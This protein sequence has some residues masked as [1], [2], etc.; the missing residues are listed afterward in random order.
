LATI[1]LH[2]SRRYFLGRLVLVPLIG[3]S[4][5]GVVEIVLDFVIPYPHGR[6]LANLT[7]EIFILPA[8][9]GLLS[10]ILVNRRNVPPAHLFAWL[11]PCAF[12]VWQWFSYPDSGYSWQYLLSDHC[13]DNECLSELFV[14]TPAVF[15][16][17][18][19]AGTALQ[20]LRLWL[21]RLQAD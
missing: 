6:F 7:V 9:V 15:S 13:R 8:V 16:I 20:T 2:E 11:L 1:F 3:F 19:T 18:F 17:A 10:G 21:F 14:T 4:A 12:F 5:A